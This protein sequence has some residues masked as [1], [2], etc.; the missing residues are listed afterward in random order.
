MSTRTK[1][2]ITYDSQDSY[3]DIGNTVNEIVKKDT[4]HSLVEAKT[5]PPRP[6]PVDLTESA[7]NELKAIEG[8]KLKDVSKEYN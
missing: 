4:G 2:L 5:L 3:Q 7:V 1:M 8:I 6:L